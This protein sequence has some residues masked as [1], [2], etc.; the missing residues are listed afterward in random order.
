MELKNLFTKEAQNT[1]SAVTGGIKKKIKPVIDMWSELVRQNVEAIQPAIQPIQQAVTNIAN[2]IIEPIKEAKYK[3]II[4]DD[5]SKFLADEGIDY[6][7]LMALPDDDGA[8]SSELL[9]FLQKNGIKVQGMEELQAQEDAKLAEEV[10]KPFALDINPKY[11]EVTALSWLTWAIPKYEYSPEDSMLKSTGKMIWNLPVSWLQMAG[12]VWDIWLSYLRNLDQWPVDAFTETAKAKII[13]PTIAQAYGIKD[14]AQEGYNEGW[15]VWS[16]N[17]LLE[18]WSEFIVENP[19]WA[20]M[21]G[22]SLGWAKRG[23]QAIKTAWQEGMKWNIGTATTGLIKSTGIGLKENIYDPIKMWVTAPITVVKLWA[24]GIWAIAK[25]T[26][27]G[28]WIAKKVENAKIRLAW[29]DE[30]EIWALEKTSHSEIDAILK[31]AE[32]TKGKQGD[33]V[34]TPYHVWAEK[35]KKTLNKLD[36]DLKTRQS[37]RLAILDEAPV[38]KIDANDARMALK[39]ALRSMNVEDIVM[40]DWGPRIIPVKWREALLDLS[41][42]ADVKALQKLNEI[43]DWDVSP[44]QTMDRVKKLQEW[45][46]ENKSTIG[47]KGTSERMDGLIKR[48]QGSLNSTFKKQLP[49]EYAKVLDSMSEDIKLSNE[50]KRLFWID[51]NWNPI[52]NRW[53]LVM[54][55]LANGTTTGWEARILAKQIYDRYWIDL[56]KEARLRQMAMDLVWDARW[57][58]LF[59][60]IK[61]GKQGIIDKALEYTVGKIVNKEKLVRWIAKG[62]WEQVKNTEPIY[63]PNA[64]RKAMSEEAKK[65]IGLPVPTGKA[66]WAKNVR[67]NQPIEKSPIKNEWQVWVRP[68]TKANIKTPE[69]VQLA[70]QTQRQEQFRQVER[71]LNTALLSKYNPNKPKAT[72][73]FLD[74]AITQGRITKE[75]AITLVENLYEKADWW[76]KPHYERMLND[77]YSNKKIE[78]WD[79]LLN[80]KQVKTVIKTPR[81]EFLET[82]EGIYREIQKKAND[83]RYNPDKADALIAKFKE[84]TGIDLMTEKTPNFDKD[85]NVVKVIKKPTPN[86]IKNES[87][88]TP[89]QTQ[90]NWPRILWK[91]WKVETKTSPQ[92]AT[93]YEAGMRRPFTMQ[94]NNPIVKRVQ[95]KPTNPLVEE[96]SVSPYRT[97]YEWARWSWT[98]NKIKTYLKDNTSDYKPAIFQREL[99]KFDSPEELKNN[100]FYHW[101]SRSISWL[102]PSIVLWDTTSFWW[103]YGEK[104]WG[105]SLSKDRNIAS[106]FTGQSDYWNVAPVLLKK[107]AKVKE[108]PNINDSIEIEDYIEKLWDEW[109]DAVKIWKNWNDW[110]SEQ[111]LVVL[112]PKAIVTGKS[113]WFRV[114]KK[115]KMPSF[116]DAKIKEI[117]DNAPEEFLKLREEWIKSHNESF[118]AK[119][120]RLPSQWTTLE[121]QKLVDIANNRLKNKPKKLSK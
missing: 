47:V 23:S 48:V 28:K 106:N 75:E 12:A 98:K 64:F 7:T 116:D 95:E 24:N 33:Y 68:W 31:Q 92:S 52:W 37:E 32:Q 82:P 117:Y 39:S 67:V 93:S 115:P 87:K 29:I 104:Y 30:N 84:K 34:Q 41:N 17:K 73:E 1:Y 49:E 35:A 59:W 79:D 114:F 121:I 94:S 97:K 54:K 60:V 20:I 3:K 2:P 61:W 6:E 120:W 103:W 44:T 46:Y 108:M 5:I 40:E 119:Y 36:A 107:W 25:K 83:R 99:L 21:T 15:V 105:I 63:M 80:E 50:I 10:N 81:Q 88:V 22:K 101:S 76:N 42:P 65:P 55:R 18:K 111:E 19:V 90:A 72:K 26:E 86:T 58:T 113:E 96:A 77:L 66:T 56:I 43:L 69:E 118:F 51:D 9:S 62:K 100:I 14:I 102:S 89:S 112:N 13:N 74:R 91:M 85:W 78:S 38:A 4:A 53:E 27:T 16:A 45:A 71:D 109:V 57:Q 110:F 70:K 11:D 8:T